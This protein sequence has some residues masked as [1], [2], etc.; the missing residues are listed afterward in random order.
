MPL[1]AYGGLGPNDKPVLCGGFYQT[2]ALGTYMECF[3][4]QNN[5]W[6]S[7]QSLTTPRID[8]AISPSPYPNK[9]HHY[10]V[11]G[12]YN[13]KNYSDDY[14]YNE[15]LNTGEILTDGGWIP[16]PVLLPVKIANH[17]MVLINSTT[18]LIIGGGQ[19]NSSIDIK[20]YKKLYPPDSVNTFFFNS[21]NEKW[22]QGP[23]KNE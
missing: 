5:A 3:L 9:S 14:Y 11:T 8:A 22:T 4:F 19:F 1:R 16:F 2:D 17:C 18:L 15:E 6:N 10:I 12:V 13:S 20:A 21:D 7:I 23:G